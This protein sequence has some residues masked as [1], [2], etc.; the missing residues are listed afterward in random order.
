MV[1]IQHTIGV[2]EEVRDALSKED[3]LKLN[4]LSNRTI[5]AASSLQDTGSITIAVMVYALSKLVERRE[6]LNIKNWPQLAKKINS[7]FTLAEKSLKENNLAKFEKYIMQ[8][9][10]T[11]SMISPELKQY[12]QDVMRKAS[13]NKASKIYEHGI[14]MGHTAKILGIT[15]WELA[16]YSGQTQVGDVNLSITLDAQKRAK[17][18]LEFFS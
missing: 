6:A 12:V 16:S 7:F 1:E 2:L 14:S 8:A 11:M 17:M 4:E 15:E 5:H 18:A 10:K 13:I 3:V 9:R